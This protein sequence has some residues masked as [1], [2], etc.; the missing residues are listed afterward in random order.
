MK[1][2]VA[3]NPCDTARN[4]GL[5]QYLWG[6]DGEKEE[7][8]MIMDYFVYS[9]CENACDCIPQI[10]ASPTVPAIS[11]ERGNCQA[12]AYWDVCRILPNIKVIKSSNQ[13]WPGGS[14]SWQEVCPLLSSWI[15]TDDGQHFPNVAYTDVHPDVTTF[16]RAYMDALQILTDSVLY[17]N[18]LMLETSQGHP[19]IEKFSILFPRQERTDSR[20][21]QVK[22]SMR[23]LPLSKTQANSAET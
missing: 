8:R 17:G 7:G 6:D 5:N 3:E 19:G 4:D 15:A 10:D 12:H 1:E 20:T 21:V 9:I 23:E 16:F 13:T 18:C 14:E 11:I 22:F 2:Y